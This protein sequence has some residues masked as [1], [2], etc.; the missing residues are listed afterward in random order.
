MILLFIILS[1]LSSWR[2]VLGGY[3][4]IER[5][6]GNQAGDEGGEDLEKAAKEK[7]EKEEEEKAKAEEEEEEKEKAKKE[8]AKKKAAKRKERRQR[9]K[10]PRPPTIVKKRTK[11][12][13]RHQS[14]RYVKI[15]VSLYEHAL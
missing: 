8:K 5:T 2:D 6:G 12:F 10:L 4:A 11:N 9:K 7:A 13:P 1:G 3:P 14:D 15:K